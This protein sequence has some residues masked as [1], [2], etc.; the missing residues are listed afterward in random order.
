MEEYLW[1]RDLQ[2]FLL[3][4]SPNNKWKGKNYTLYLCQK[5]YE[6]T[7]TNW[8]QNSS[9]VWSMCLSRK[10]T[11]SKTDTVPVV[12]AG[13]LGWFATFLLE[14]NINYFP[15]LSSLLEDSS[16]LLAIGRIE[17][18]LTCPLSPFHTLTK[19][20]CPWVSIVEKHLFFNV[21]VSKQLAALITGDFL[22]ETEGLLAWGYSWFTQQSHNHWEGYGERFTCAFA[23]LS[24]RNPMKSSNSAVLL[25]LKGGMLAIFLKSI[26]KNYSIQSQ[27]QPCGAVHCIILQY[28]KALP[29][30]Q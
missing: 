28:G 30:T 19:H 24:S 25:H 6:V 9:L 20:C 21:K 16:V 4:Q 3:A 22:T 15:A 14:A 10:G 13:W 12:A 23:Y 17:R 18:D 11:F 29:K 8:D 27:H 26:F 5:Q 1:T 7:S 2:F